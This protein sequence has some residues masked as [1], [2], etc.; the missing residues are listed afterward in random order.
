MRMSDTSVVLVGPKGRVVIPAR[1]RR[2]LGIREGSELVAVVDGP[3]VV[4]VPR[5]AVKS[6]LR[7]LFAGVSSSL[8]DELIADRRAA[9]ARE[10]AQG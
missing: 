4:L 7:S 9:A 3:A 1:I 2:E 8:S 6:R 5:A 10:S